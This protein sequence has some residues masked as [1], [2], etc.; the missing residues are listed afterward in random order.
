MKLKRLA[1]IALLGA[2]PV[3][4]CGDD[5]EP[6][7]PDIGEV[8]GTW[9][10]GPDNAGTSLIVTPDLPLAPSVDVVNTLQGTISL[11]ITTAERFTL[12]VTIVDLQV[13]E[14]VT[15]DF[16]ITGN[17]RARLTRDDDPDDPLT[18]SISLSG[19]VLNVVVQNAVLFD[20][21]M[22]EEVTDADAAEIDG[23][24]VRS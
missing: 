5:D 22:D 4:G 7:G 21:N 10:A 23:K 19:D 6:T 14:L 9:I 18:A 15:G 20:V 11:T 2:L 17:N 16:E 1:L 3:L 8:A 24:F 12:A 13:D